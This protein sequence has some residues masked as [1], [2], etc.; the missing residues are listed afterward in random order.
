MK[1]IFIFTLFAIFIFTDCK[2]QSNFDKNKV[3][4]FFQNQQ[5]DEAIAYL[6]NTISNDG[7]NI[8]TLSY[9]AYANYMNDN[10]EAAEKYYREV[11][12]LDSNNIAAINNLA[13]LNKNS[14]PDEALQLTR[15]LIT[16][17]PAK[18]ANYRNLAELFKRKQKTDSAFWYYNKAYELSP[19]DLKNA[20]G[21]AEALID[22]KMFLR[23]D[24]I[25]NIGLIADSNNI[26]LLKLSIRSAYNAKNYEAV[27]TPGEKLMRLNEPAIAAFTQTIL[28]YYALKEY[29]NCITVCDYLDLKNWNNEKILFYEAKAYAQ[30]KD[31]NKSNELLKTC[32]DMAISKDAESYY[33][34]LAK[35]FEELKEYKKAIANYDTAYYLFKNATINYYCGRICE[36]NLKNIP[37]AQKYYSEYL[38]KARPVEADEKKAYAY[39]KEKWSKGKTTK[40]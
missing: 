6:S 8:Q 37:L 5:Y 38:A 33:L 21:F 10:D 26:P 24:S 28:S 20:A 13:S 25:I 15:R 31:F 29:P 14:N 9:L 19:K 1:K 17:Q 2:A 34:N 32:I 30:L 11:F 7:K 36:I 18:A 27:R 4:E 3:L 39:V 12:S 35:N 16:L 40:K 23:A 22:S